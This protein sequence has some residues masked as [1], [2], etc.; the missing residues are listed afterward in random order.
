M[1]TRRSAAAAA[2][3]T[4]ATTADEPKKATAEKVTASK[5]RKAE[6]V[7][8]ESAPKSKKAKADDKKVT[9]VSAK[10]TETTKAKAAPKKAESKKPATKKAATKKAE[11]KKT[12]NKVTKKTVSKKTKKEIEAITKEVAKTKAAPRP[13]KAPVVKEPPAPKVRKAGQK[14]NDAPTQRLEIYVFGEGSSGELGMGSKRRDGKKPI[15]VKRPRY[16]DVISAKD[17]GVVQVACGGMHV[18]ALTA[19]GKMLTWG[20]NDDGALGRSTEWD[21]GLRDMDKEEDSDSDDEDDTGVNPLESTPSAVS[22]DG[23]IE[24]TKIVQVVACDSATFALTEDG[25]VYGWGTF[26]ASDGILGFSEETKVQRTPL[27]IAGLKNIK[28]LAAGSNHVLAINAKNEVTAWGSGE[29]SQLGRRIGERY[30]MKALQPQHVGIPKSKTNHIVKMACG[31][32]HS[33]ALTSDGKV[34]GWGLN[35]FGQ[36]GVEGGAGEGEAMVTSPCI[37]K[38]LSEYKIKDIAGG[39]HHSLACTE[40][41][42]LLVWGR[43][44]GHQVGLPKEAYTEENTVFDE[45]E[46]PRLLFKPT[47]IKDIPTVETVAAGT[48]T[49]FAVTTEGKVYTWGFSANYQTGLGTTDDIEEPTIIENSAIKE[50]RVVFAGAGGQYSLLCALPTDAELIEGKASG[51]EVK[52]ETT[53]A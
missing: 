47:E 19:D 40:D 23:F 13:K 6:E 35:N 8:A 17:S 24:G 42:K 27:E 14:I 29:Q 7:E 25:R 2:K 49:S 51:T 50:K 10:K 48:D 3:A 39:E 32:Y 37:I 44:D 28:R 22:T 43:I 52:V 46:R 34:Y 16:N 26:R 1:A 45:N 53:P 18:A 4:K 20:V 12:D 33:F 36:V 38:A 9:K 21:G 5:K 11:V 30:K 31:S 41:G 15:D